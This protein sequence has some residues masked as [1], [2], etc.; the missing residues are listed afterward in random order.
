VQLLFAGEGPWQTPIEVPPRTEKLFPY[1]FT[2]E[3]IYVPSTAVLAPTRGAGSQCALGAEIPLHV[4]LLRVSTWSS[5]SF[6]PTTFRTAAPAFLLEKTN[7]AS[8][9]GFPSFF[10]FSWRTCTGPVSLFCV[11]PLFPST[12]PP[13]L[14]VLFT[15][16]TW[17]RH[18]PSS[19]RKD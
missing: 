16:C 17:R 19:F 4:L 15:R 5:F 3:S 13:Q 14:E 12:E 7:F 18:S 9:Y 10:S 2:S 1:L 11:G 6:S 8:F